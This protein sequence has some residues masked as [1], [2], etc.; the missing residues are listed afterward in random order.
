[1]TLQV[2]GWQVLPEKQRKW[3]EKKKE[4]KI[5]MRMLNEYGQTVK[6]GANTG[7]SELGRVLGVKISGS[8]DV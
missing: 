5:I 3:R 1:M 6:R 7:T 2:D 8:Q 4:E